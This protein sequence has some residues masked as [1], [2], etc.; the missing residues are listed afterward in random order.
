MAK[1]DPTIPEHTHCATLSIFSAD[2]TPDV[3]VQVDWD[4]KLTGTSMHELG[5]YP[6]AYK[7]VQEYIKPMLEAA[8]NDND[9]DL[10][11][12]EAASDTV[13]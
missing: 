7:F 12:A 5:Y 9:E 13:N 2:D 1:K 3:W 6:A 11:T 8:F 10:L 4:P